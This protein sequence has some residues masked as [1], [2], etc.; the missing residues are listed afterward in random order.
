MPCRG[1]FSIATAKVSATSA[2]HTLLHL[3][4]H[5]TLHGFQQCS[6][7]RRAFSSTFT[8]TLADPANKLQSYVSTSND[9]YLNLSIED[10]ILRRSPADSTILFLYVNR[11]CVVIGRNQNPWSEV[12]LGILNAA[13][14]AHDL[15]D[16]EPPGIGT[17]QLV[18]RRSGG[19]TVFHDEG[20]LNWSITCPR[21]DFTRDKHAEM[22]VR[23]LRKLGVERARVNERHDIV[24]D[25]GNERRASDP[26]DTHRTPYTIQ[27]GILPRPLKVSG[28][29]YK[30][31]RQR[32]LHHATTLLSSP[33]LHIIPHYLR[34]PAK[35]FI[36]AQGVESVSS[37]VSNIGLDVKA[38]QSRLQEEFALMYAEL[39]T[40]SIVQTVGDDFLEIP[41]IRKGYDELQ[42]EEWMW[43]QT[44]AFSLTFG[45]VDNVG[46]E[47]K[48]HHGAI[49]SL[50]FEHS[51]L[52][53]ETQS[54]LR[55]ALVGLQLQEIR[56]WT[57]FLQNRIHAWDEQ[58]A[59]IGNR[60]D[61]LLP[62]PEA[63][64]I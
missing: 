20:N 4:P 15:K 60:L 22:V 26:N 58:M 7:T 8:E 61:D 12:N 18:R 2:S 44:P 33:N 36:R 62:V 54:A 35:N 45:L 9:P 47:I 1:F 34:S 13:R 43:A 5:R 53:D 37:P 64:K 42:T 28:S 17:V 10:H 56:N 55:S 39:G 40:P 23:A 27:D 57:A 52:S 63:Y 21:A 32:A 38:F 48:V 16:S 19:G 46:I 51:E 50:N 31:T 24:L 41:D 49:K 14:G 59:A 25:Q 3:Q 29:A 6:I 11:P 30:L